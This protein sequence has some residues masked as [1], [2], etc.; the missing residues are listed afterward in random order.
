MNDND[1]I[2][3]LEHCVKS[4]NCATCMYK[5]SC[6]DLPQGALKLITQQKA[7]IERLNHIRAELSKENE[8]QDQAIINALHRMKVVRTESIK[9]FWERLQKDFNGVFA[10]E[11][12]CVLS[13]I[14]L[15][16]E[17]MTEDNNA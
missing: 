5:S 17:E 12:P 8:E 6:I 7:E 15:L 1:I 4:G 2:K 11:H 10:K 16:V 3:A 13:E 14:D 9:E